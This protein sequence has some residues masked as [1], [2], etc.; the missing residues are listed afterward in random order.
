MAR[1]VGAAEEERMV[2]EGMTLTS[3]PAPNGDVV[4]KDENEEEADESRSEDGEGE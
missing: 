3:C 2:E 4:D 1:L